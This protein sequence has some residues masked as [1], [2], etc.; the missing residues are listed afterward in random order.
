MNREHWMELALSEAEKCLKTGDIPVG[1]VIVCGGE[2]IAAGHNCREA[3]R[4]VLGHAE[5]MALDAACRRL[6]RWRLSDCELYVTLEPCPMCAGAI[7]NARL[8]A[9]IYGA[10]EPKT[11]SCGSVV[12]LFEE[13]YPYRVPV[14]GGVLEDRCA[15]IMQHFFDTLR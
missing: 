15:G 10:C 14:Y 5:I 4:N 3:A 9:L 1:C 6:G 7:L 11:G 13:P 12:N 8:G 2:V